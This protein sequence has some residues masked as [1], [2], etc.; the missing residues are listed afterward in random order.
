MKHTQQCRFVSGPAKGCKKQAPVFVDRFGTRA[1]G[2]RVG[3][4]VV[5][6]RRQKQLSVAT[7]VVPSC[8]CVWFGD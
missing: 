3:A 7:G 5:V 2:S 1:V 8:L 4:A 6:A